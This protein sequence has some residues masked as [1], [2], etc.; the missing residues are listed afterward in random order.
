MKTTL[1][2][3]SAEVQG[4]GQHSKLGKD[5]IRGLQQDLQLRKKSRENLEKQDHSRGVKVSVISSRPIPGQ[6]NVH[7]ALTAKTKTTFQHAQIKHKPDKD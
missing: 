2:R 6:S 3:L 1:R 5:Q 4:S 7:I